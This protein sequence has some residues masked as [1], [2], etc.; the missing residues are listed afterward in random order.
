MQ[1][2][3]IAGNVGKDA[4]LRHTQNNDPILGFSVAVSNG[5]DKDATWYDC[6]VWGP[7]AEKLEP[8]IKKGSKLTLT[9]RPTVR[10][11]EGKAYLG[12]SVND[13][14]FMGGGERS[15]NTGGGSSS[16]QARES[17]DLNDMSD[18]PFVRAAGDHDV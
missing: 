10:V 5:K 2:L 4:V 3:T 1:I 15:E 16:G 6:S 14:T 12:L 7:R 18:I 9:G 13:L 11:H 17:Y 8:Y